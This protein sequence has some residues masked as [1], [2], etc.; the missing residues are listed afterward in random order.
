MCCL[1]SVQL[2]KILERKIVIS[3]LIYQFKLVCLDAQ[4]NRLTETVLLS[5]HN[6]CLVEKLEK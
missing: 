5:I 1:A 6:I 2:S 3:F 4:K